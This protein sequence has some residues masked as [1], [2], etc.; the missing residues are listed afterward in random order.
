MHSARL[1][2]LADGSFR[3][4]LP[5][6]DPD[7]IAAS[8]AMEGIDVTD[9]VMHRDAY[10]TAAPPLE[11]APPEPARIEEPEERRP[12]RRGETRVITFPANRP[13]SVRASRAG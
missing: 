4:C 1:S 6:A 8:P 7:V 13:R 12:L 11:L 5:D 2:H 10:A 9:E 3:P